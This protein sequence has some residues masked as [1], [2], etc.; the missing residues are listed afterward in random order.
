MF[1]ARHRWSH[2]ERRKDSEM[3]DRIARIFLLAALALV[4]VLYIA[5]MWFGIQLMP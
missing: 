1:C 3:I 5:L 4:V 2:G